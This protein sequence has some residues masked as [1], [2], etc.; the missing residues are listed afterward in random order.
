MSATTVPADQF[1]DF[2]RRGLS[3]AY[4]DFKRNHA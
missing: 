4:D 2:H 3:H 1:A